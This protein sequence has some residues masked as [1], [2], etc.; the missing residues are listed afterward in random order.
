MKLL[1]VID[2]LGSGGAQRQMT[3]LAIG[4]K[5]KG[6]SVNLFEYYP[7][8]NHFERSLVDAGI[9][10]IKAEKSHRFSLSVVRHLDGQIRSGHY[11]CVLA[12]LN[13]P[14]FYAE[15][16]SLFHF[17]LPLVVSVRSAFPS[18]LG[19]KIWLLQQMHRLAHHIV[20]NSHHQRI[21]MEMQFKW[22][23][24]KISTICNGVDL[25][26]FKPGEQ[27]ALG[28]LRLLCLGSV[29]GN[30]NPVNLVRAIARCRDDYGFLP[31]VDWAGKFMF[32]RDSRRVFAEAN[33]VI[34]SLDLNGSW[35]WL[36]ERNDV[37]GLITTHH[38]LVNTSFSEGLPNAVCEALACGRP[39]LASNVCDH[40]RLVH[41][42]RTGYLF[43]PGSPESIAGAIQKLAM[44]SPLDRQEMSK[45]ARRF[46]AAELSLDGFVDAYDLLFTQ[47]AGA[48][49]TASVPNC[50]DQE[51]SVDKGPA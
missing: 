6:H 9:P 35:H 14:I 12:Y 19:L 17:G 26:I 46:A 11:D 44:L 48:G 8:H 50:E 38:A 45:E 7:E 4:L 32:S 25:A 15:T 47:L 49:E 42:G 40:P 20:V 36:G 1:F 22:M 29:T 16:V 39:V 5:S 28:G 13:T 41:D 34:N 23:R 3:Q 24:S 31:T 43:D 27:P 10:I 51:G 33:R 30:K 18:R 21:R 37:P 2:S